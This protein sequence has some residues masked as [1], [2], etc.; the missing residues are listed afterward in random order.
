[1]AVKVGINGFGRIG[2]QVLK[3]IK[4][5]HGSE[6]EVVAINDLFDVKT[7]AHLFKYDSNYGQYHGTVEVDGNDL[8]VDGKKIKVFAEKDPSKLPWKDLGVDIVVESTGIFTDAVGEP[9][10]GKPGANV[11]IKSGGA[12]KV[13]ISAP[14]K[15]E[16]LTIVLGVNEEKY[17]PKMHH[18]LSNASCT[19]NCI[20][21]AAKVINDKF[22][23]QYA[24]MTTIHSYTNDQVILDQ[25]H[26]KEMRRSRAAC[27]NIIPTTTGAAKAIALVIPEL[28][29]KF[30]GYSLRVPTPTVSIVDF[31]ATVEKPTTLEEVNSAF[32]EASKTTL[33]GILG[34]TTGEYNDPLVSSD[35]KGDPRSS[36]VD[37]KN[38]M[39]MGGTLVKVVT[40]Y[41]NEWGYSCRT[42]DLAAMIAKSL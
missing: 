14:A 5:L 29:G 34:V 16:D 40:W 33:K 41:D 27:L 32:V 22:K 21:P 4:E 3:A 38:N 25:G 15:N 24:V 7:N 35:F 30:D 28:K 8:V 9:E 10:K 17:D 13:I 2:R 1:M 39:V 31:V 37:L 19:T 23:I 26:K 12:K 6:L 11:H 42:A 36:I 18:V 20:A